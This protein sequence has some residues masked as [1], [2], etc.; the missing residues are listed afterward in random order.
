MQFITDITATIN[1]DG[2]KDK[3]RLAE[4]LKSFH[5]EKKGTCY[6]VRGSYEK[7]ECLSNRLSALNHQL[8]PATRGRT[9]HQHSVRPVDVSWVVMNYIEKKRTKELDRIRDDGF[10]IEMQPDLRTARNNPGVIVQLSFIPKH[11]SIQPVHLD[12]VRQRFISFYQRTASDLQVTSLRVSPHDHRDLH[13]RFPCL[14][15]EPSHNKNELI[16]IG[17]FMHIAKLEEHLLRG[18][19]SP[20]KSTVSK[21]PSSS[22]APSPAPTRTKDPEDETCPIC[23]E[24]IT[25]KKTLRCKHSFCRDCVKR[26]FAYKPVCPTCGQLY[27]TLTGTQPDGGKMTV[28]K[29]SSSLPGHKEYGT[30][31]VSYYIPSGI[32]KVMID[33]YHFKLFI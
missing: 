17:P 23:M 6:E 19:P 29:N 31:M 2:Y 15:L 16:V 10:A 13:K 26:A 12:F 18:T 20:S 24:P 3:E 25:E 32:Q 11:G 30:I 22:S 27:G 7:I 4:I 14:L 33:F 9:H 5:A 8:S 28:S 21:G 1:E